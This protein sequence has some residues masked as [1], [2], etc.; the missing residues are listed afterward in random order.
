MGD[1][2]LD[3]HGAL[4]FTEWL[5]QRCRSREDADK[6]A[7]VLRTIPAGTWRIRWHHYTDDTQ[8]DITTIEPRDGLYIHVRLQADDVDQYTIASISDVPIEDDEG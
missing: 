4:V 1:L 3:P 7:E 8:P 5:T 2:R 6:V